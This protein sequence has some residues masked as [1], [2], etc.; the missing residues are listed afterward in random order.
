MVTVAF[1]DCR[2]PVD[3]FSDQTDKYNCEWV[4]SQQVGQRYVRV[5]EPLT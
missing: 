4:L 1:G 3:D 5:L 2:E